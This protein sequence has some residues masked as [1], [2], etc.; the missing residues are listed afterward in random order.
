M[1]TEHETGKESLRPIKEN[2]SPRRSTGKE[3]PDR[4]RAD[5]TVDRSL[6][7]AYEGH[8]PVQYSDES[9][10]TFAQRKAQ[11]DSDRASAQ[12]TDSGNPIP[13]LRKKEDARHELEKTNLDAQ[14]KGQ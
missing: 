3:I 8:D 13:S 7:A 4:K 12:G 14:E 6:D 5:G 10:E 9:D 11:F 1:G 2:E